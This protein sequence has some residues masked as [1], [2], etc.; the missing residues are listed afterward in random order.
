M[1][2]LPSGHRFLSA[3]TG[4]ALDPGTWVP[5]AGALV[6]TID[7]W[8]H[9]V[10]RWA[11]RKTPVFGSNDKA[12]RASTNLRDGLLVWA[13]ITTIATPGGEDMGPWLLSKAKGG[14]VEFGAW[15][16]S[17]MAT[18]GLKSTTGRNR[19]DNSS[20]QS[21]PSGHSTQAFS[22]SAI[23]TLNINTIGIPPAIRTGLRI[24]TVTAAVG[25]AWAR[26]EAGRHYPTDVLAGAALANF[27]TVFIYRSFLDLPGD[28]I[29]AISIAPAEDGIMARFYQSF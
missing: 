25:T 20:D 24:T 16:L 29:P 2:L 8:D 14:L 26:V 6:F 19:P 9:K 7:D 4:A 10:S 17:R 13:G 3:L 1:T 21:F 11:T 22:A 27:I 18:N 28:D 12:D 23:A 15:K 5:T